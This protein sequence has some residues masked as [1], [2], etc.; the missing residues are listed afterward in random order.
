M[1][2][3]VEHMQNL[4]TNQAHISTVNYLCQSICNEI[5]GI[6]IPLPTLTKL[7]SCMFYITFA[8]QCNIN[9]QT[10]W[11]DKLFINSKYSAIKVQY[12]TI[13][14][15]IDLITKQRVYHDGGVPS[16]GFNMST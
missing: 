8:N 14:N 9:S 11:L 12:L 16:H 15:V 13:H 4:Y 3:I 6:P 1:H 2:Y 5:L 10:L 7:A